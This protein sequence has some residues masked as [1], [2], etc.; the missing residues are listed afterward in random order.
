MSGTSDE[1]N[2]VEVL[3]DEFLARE[4]RGERPSLSEYVTR[5]PELAEDIHELFP[6]LLDME[7][8][9]LDAAEAPG[10]AAGIGGHAPRSLGDYRILREI[11]RGGMAVVY[12]AEQESLGRR[13]ALKVLARTALSSQQIRRFEREARSAG[14]LHHTN[15]VPVFGVGHEGNIHYY[16]MQYIPGQPL[17]QVIKEV[18]R[19]RRGH[20][21]PGRHLTGATGARADD[22]PSAG[23]VALSLWNGRGIPPVMDRGPEERGIPDSPTTDLTL[24][25]RT[26]QNEAVTPDPPVNLAGSAIPSCSD[27]DVFSSSVDLTGSGTRYARA[28]AHIGVQVA[29]ALEYAALQGIIHR[30]VK[31]SNIL[32]DL[33]G[34]AWVTDF[35]LAKVAGLEDLTQSGDLVG[36][37]RYM[38]PERFRGEADRRS[39]LYALGLTLYELLV[40]RPAH[41]ESDRVRLVRQVTDEEVPR[42]SKLDPTIPLGS[43]NDR[44][45]GDGARAGRARTRPPPRWRPT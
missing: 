8:A 17:D 24:P 34:T 38:A 12:E 44:A 45:Q 42:L 41:D 33:G 1:R 4:R 20:H 2:P 14:R 3:A 30:D 25:D 13:V 32:L 23:E 39:D 11:G 18:R 27:A 40:L 15:I 6:V 22:R 21:R 7:D 9:R 16:V 37:L 26:A 29:D 36:T 35:G 43:G 28:I 31:P 10:P 19:L 5:Y